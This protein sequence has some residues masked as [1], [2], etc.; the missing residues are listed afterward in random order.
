MPDREVSGR[1]SRRV[2]AS[3]TVL[4]VVVLNFPMPLSRSVA[5]R[6]GTLILKKPSVR[7]YRMSI[8]QLS[9]EVRLHKSSYIVKP[10]ASN[11]A[12]PF[13]SFMC[14]IQFLE[15]QPWSD[16]HGI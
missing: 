8:S 13:Q 14:P 7:P 15:T 11:D 1:L 5:V 12:D 10:E 4:F 9:L 3:A 16:F 2:T 6:A